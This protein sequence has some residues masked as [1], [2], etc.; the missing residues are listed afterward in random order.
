[1]DSQ[2]K[3]ISFEQGD[4]FLLSGESGL[5]TGLKALHRLLHGRHVLIDQR[6][7]VARYIQVVIVGSD[8]LQRDHARHA[9]HILIIVIPAVDAL[10]MLGQQLVLGATAL[11]L[12]RGVE[13]E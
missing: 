13:D 12:L 2:Q 3:P 11:E 4:E 7:D 1:M 5:G 8:L 6:L 10:D 9:C